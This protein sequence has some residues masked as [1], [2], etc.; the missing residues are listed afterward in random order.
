VKNKTKVGN[1][2]Y[3]RNDVQFDLPHLDWNNAR[4]VGFVNRMDRDVDLY[5]VNYKEQ[6]E[7]LI[8]AKLSPGAVHYEITYHMHI[9][10]ARFHGDES[11]TIIDEFQ[12]RDVEIY[13]C[14]LP[15]V[16]NIQKKG[17]TK[18]VTVNEGLPVEEYAW[19]WAISNRTFVGV[20]SI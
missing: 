11:S 19:T 13:D 3:Q 15:K 18:R 17:E 7:V 10:R 1:L 6:S 12:I 5:Y 14:E 4:E 20:Y 16:R 9:F 8:A 2:H